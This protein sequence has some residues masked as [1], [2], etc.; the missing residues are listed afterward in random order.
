MVRKDTRCLSPRMELLGLQKAIFERNDHIIRAEAIVEE[1]GFAP[2]ERR[3]KKFV[4]DFEQA[5]KIEE[6]LKA[7]EDADIIYIGDYHT[8]PQSQRTLLRLLKLLI[9]RLSS[10]GIAV[11]LVRDD[12]QKV[13]DRFLAD[14]ISEKHFLKKI[15]FKKYWYFD[16]WQNFKPVFDFSRYHSIPVYGVESAEAEG[17][18]LRE[19]DKKSG[20]IIADVMEQHPE[21]KLFVF[22]GDLHIAPDHLPKE[23]DRALAEKGLKRKRLILYQNSESIYWKLAEQRREE[24]VEI[25]KINNESYCLVITPPIVWQQTFLNWLEHEGETID[26]ADAKH[27]VL[28]LVE[29]IAD[30]LE[31]RLPKYY[32][33]MEV[34]TCGDLSFLEALKKDKSFTS[35]E[36]KTIRHQILSSESYFIARKRYIYLANVSIN[37]AAEEAAHY[38]KYLCSGEERERPL[39]DAFYANT[40]HEAIGFFGSKIVNHKRKCLHERQINELIEY[41]SSI[42][43]PSKRRIELEMAHLVLE[44]KKRERRKNPTP[45]RESVPHETDVFLGTT[46]MLGYMLGDRLYY[47][48][49]GGIISKQEV[50]HLFMLRM[51][52]EN[53]PFTVYMDLIKKTSKVKLPRRL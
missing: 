14:K 16:L 51:Q 36:L 41:L 40:I 6:V 9:G 50:R 24:K 42:H 39:A 4:S 35:K 2:Y 30:F 34:F 47:S 10:L 33:E 15:E 53:E 11:E 49:L 43:F 8:N 19:R 26:Y 13:L 52:E 48:L 45:Y 38:L 17:K 1:P 5:S 25:V 20:E 28:E 44:H 31:L 23:V 32:E 7:I 21:Q 29:R 22:V 3:Y 18:G 46:H 37:H 27:T 12:Q